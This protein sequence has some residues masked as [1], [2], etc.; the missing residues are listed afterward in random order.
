MNPYLEN[1][2]FWAELHHRL[3]TAIAD[4]I[5]ANIPQQYHVAIEQRTY[6]SDDSDTISVFSKQLAPQLSTSCFRLRGG[7]D[8]RQPKPI[9][10]HNFIN[11]SCVNCTKD[12]EPGD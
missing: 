7:F 1:P 5:E 4:A 11:N 10:Y 12:L 2:V 6:L 9:K 8:W 3:I